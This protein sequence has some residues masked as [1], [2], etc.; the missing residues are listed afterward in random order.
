MARA[1]RFLKN[2][3]RY[4]RRRTERALAGRVPLPTREFG[5]MIADNENTKPDERR[6]EDD[7]KP[8][9]DG[10]PK[11]TRDIDEALDESFPASDPPSFNPGT[12]KRHGD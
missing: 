10:K 6:K 11:S 1:A 12:T 7:Q 2:R 8:R 9:D 3:A 5:L 4:R